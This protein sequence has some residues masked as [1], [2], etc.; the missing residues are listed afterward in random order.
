MSAFIDTT[1]P[2]AMRDHI[3][4]L[5]ELADQLDEIEQRR[6]DA[7][8]L[9]IAERDE[10]VRLRSWMAAISAGNCYSVVELRQMAASALSGDMPPPQD[11]WR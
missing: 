5:R 6:G 2:Y 9:V 1:S 8:D 3:S 4:R 7:L 11:D 10:N